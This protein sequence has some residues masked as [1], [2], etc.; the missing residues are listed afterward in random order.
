MCMC[1][2][3]SFASDS[4]EPQRVYYSSP[5]S[6]VHG[7]S[8]GKNT[9]VGCHTLLQGIF[10]TQG[11]NPGLLYYRSILYHLSHQGSPCIFHSEFNFSHPCMQLCVR[12]PVTASQPWLFLKLSGKFKNSDPCLFTLLIVS[13]VVQKILNLIRSHLFIFAFISSTLGGG[14]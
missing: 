4:L 12:I 8:P 9:G 10:P 5:G 1:L 6:L 14:S 11:L 2:V 13:F 3:A 7:D